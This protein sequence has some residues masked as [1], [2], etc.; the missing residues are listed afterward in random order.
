[1]FSGKWEEYNEDLKQD[2]WVLLEHEKYF[3]KIEN[4]EN[5]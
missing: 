2:V 5:K 4:E 1:M 3:K